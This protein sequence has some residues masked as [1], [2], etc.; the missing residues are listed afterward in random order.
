MTRSESSP[1]RTPALDLRVNARSLAFLFGA[2]ATLLVI[3]LFVPHVGRA[4]EP[5][6]LVLAVA[7][8]AVTVLLLT[9][10]GRLGYRGQHL[11][12]V[13]GTTL[14][15]LG[16]YFSGAVAPYAAFYVWV[17]LYAFYF[18]TREQALLHLVF[19][20][21]AYAAAL[22][23]APGPAE[24]D[25]WVVTIG[26]AAVA[27][28]FV[29]RLVEEIR[30]RAAQAAG[31][32][33]RLAAAQRRTRSILEAASDGFVAVDAG[34]TII[35][36]NP[37]AEHMCGWSREELVG[38]PVASTLIPADRRAEFTRWLEHS[39]R[40]DPER[41]LADRNLEFVA[42]HRDGHEFPIEASVSSL[43]DGEGWEFSAFVRDISE[44][45]R[46]ERHMREQIED[47]EVVASVARDLA[48]VTSAHAA[49]PAICKA[50]AQLA[51]AS[52]GVLLEPDAKGTALTATAIYG[53]ADRQLSV[54]FAGPPSGAGTVFSSG[55]PL[56]V[57]ELASHP[58]VNQRIVREL[59]VASAL[60][61]P[62][63]RNAM[64]IGVLVV[65]WSERVERV[66][67]RVTS[68]IALL[69]AEAAVAIERADLLGRL[70]AV[71]RT[72]ELTGL[73][74]RRAWDENLARELA[75]ARREESP[76]CV[77]ML[78]LDHFKAFNDRNG[79]PAGDR[80]LKEVT[81]VWRALL[82]PSDVLAR[83]GGEEFTLLLPQCELDAAVEVVERLRL[84]GSD[85]QTCSAGVVQWDGEESAEALLGRV[86]RALYD[87]K[88][89][90]R[91]RAVAG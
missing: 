55:R 74:N 1:S 4:N 16:V 88:K 77:A 21:A 5:A 90:G 34:G 41:P 76:L 78:D 51:D 65:A 9:A 20:A 35:D 50:A 11:V 80:L 84:V 30:R 13:L 24:V 10:P 64:P 45:K 91:D 39:R 79:H 53:T 27:G 17:C 71:A 29:G 47:L 36:L 38:R 83:Y 66:T 62:I 49:R 86:D 72:D 15:S 26:T 6:L 67:A 18:F 14:I 52:I 73:A 2:G 33:A 25:R 87:A 61:H 32:A 22:E 75:R 85:G 7:A 48:G 37:Q 81:S 59:G 8:F 69:A 82:R 57:S 3:S 70:E 43:H 56:F 68:L 60:W 46:A 58:A 31:R 44:R 12:V 28:L 89:A 23:F 42:L 54:P 63:L 40:A 19:V